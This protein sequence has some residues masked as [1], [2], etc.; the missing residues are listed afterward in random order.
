MAR[1]PKKIN[2]GVILGLP[3]L[4]HLMLFFVYPLVFSFVLVFHRWDI[5]TPM[6]FVGMRNIGRIFRRRGFPAIDH[7]YRGIPDA[8]HPPA[9]Y[10]GALFRRAAE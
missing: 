5:V 6:E 3:Y 4:A 2:P 7:Q 1:Y 9:D 10:C 8:A